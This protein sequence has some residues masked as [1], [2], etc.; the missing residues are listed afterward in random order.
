M[1]T[2]LRLAMDNVDAMGERTAEELLALN[3]VQYCTETQIEISDD[4]VAAA[5]RFD[6]AAAVQREREDDERRA[7][8]QAET[9]MKAAALDAAHKRSQ[10][11]ADANTVVSRAIAR[12]GF[13]TTAW[14]P[15]AALFAEAIGK[16]LLDVQNADKPVHD[17]GFS[18]TSSASEIARGTAVGAIL[19]KF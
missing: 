6:M 8:E 13:D 15:A 10:A 3:E 2:S 18:A 4:V 5:Q 9:A 1:K 7:V 11:L 19:S 16:M 17:S 12:A 14:P